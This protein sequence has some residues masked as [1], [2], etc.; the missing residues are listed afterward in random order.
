MKE[1]GNHIITLFKKYFNKNASRIETRELEQE[2]QENPYLRDAMEGI[3]KM[4][5]VNRRSSIE[6]LEDRLAKRIGNKQSKKSPMPWLKLAAGIA[7]LLSVG[8]FIWRP[9]SNMEKM[10]NLHEKNTEE[11]Q[12]TANQ[13]LKKDKIYYVAEDSQSADKS[14]DVEK[15]NESDLIF[16]IPDQIGDQH[17]NQELLEIST[18]VA[19]YDDRVENANDA[20]YKK[21]KENKRISQNA[22]SNS[23]VQKNDSKTYYWDGN[24]NE[25]VEQDS[26]NFTMANNEMPQSNDRETTNKSHEGVVIDGIVYTDGSPIE[27]SG[28]FNPTPTSPSKVES[29]AEE[30]RIVSP[31]AYQ[32]QLV[33]NTT[34]SKAKKRNQTKKI[35]G[36]ITDQF[37]EVLIGVSVFEKGTRNG[38]TTDIDGTYSLEIPDDAN[39][40]VI[41]YTGFDTQEVTLDNS[42]QVDV[43]LEQGVE[44][45]EV[46]ITGLGSSDQR[47]STASYSDYPSEGMN[48]FKA[49]VKANL[50][51]P[52][53]AKEAGIK[54]KVILLFDVNNA[55]RP[56]NIEI[57]KSLGSGCDEEA[58]RLLEEGPKWEQG[59]REGKTKL[60]I[61]F[62]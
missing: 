29:R 60:T 28:P 25:E 7:L 39:S 61:R 31:E 55:G 11:S 10:S 1:S 24:T 35:E 3:D 40:L 33:E 46:V 58:I 26:E 18:S 8:F 4:S 49:Y 54:G 53:A 56:I 12:A 13:N 17:I 50:A 41:S 15:N 42:N 59:N 37:G 22:N 44:L 16:Q 14:A 36:T 6:S 43:S 62:K 23:T 48:K 52:Q 5:M 45:S 51:Y 57:K 32:E 19:S 27:S 9:F 20:F 47:E 30:D 34:R 21:T 38:T 2:A